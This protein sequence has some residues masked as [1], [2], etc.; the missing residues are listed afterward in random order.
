MSIDYAT[1]LSLRSGEV[2]TLSTEL[3]PPSPYVFGYQILDQLLAHVMDAAGAVPVDRF[4]LVSDFTVASLY[5]RSI[6]AAL[7]DSGLEVQALTLSCG[8]SVKSFRHLE[9][10]CE[11]LVA[12]GATKWS[13]IVALGG[14]VIGNV[15]GLAAGLLFRGVR[16][17]EIPTSFTHLTD[18]TLSN[19]QAINGRSGKNHFGLYH[20]PILIW[21]DTQYLTSESRRF[22][23]SGLVEGIKNGLIDQPAFLTYLRAALHPD[24]VYTPSELTE[25]AYK[26]VLSKLEILKKDPT[27]KHYC[28]VLEYGHTFAHAIEW[29]S[30]GGLT[31]G[32]AVGIGMRIAARLAHHLDLI[33]EEI[34]EVHDSLICRHLGMYVTLPEAATNEE[35]LK[36]M[37]VDNKKTGNVIRYCL[38]ERLGA[39]A[40]P[41]GDHLV[42]VEDHTAIDVLRSFEIE[43]RTAYGRTPM[44]HDARTRHDNF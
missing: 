40:N 32:E 26:T 5:G 15:V 1:P 24:G 17:V 19:K 18:G 43:M 6:H 39:C 31:H 10:L 2:L 38:L 11:M 42:T 7:S 20:A 21:G 14:G 4:F 13:V 22:R 36:T 33:P 3:L 34:V 41:E 25:L 23:D 9:N 12:L 8:E 30:R 16:Y 27:E 37:G 28:I 35:I 29:L 44:L